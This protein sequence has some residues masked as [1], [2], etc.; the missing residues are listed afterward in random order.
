MSVHRPT[1]SMH[2]RVIFKKK[3]K[4]KKN[5]EIHLFSLEIR[6]KEVESFKED[7][8]LNSTLVHRVRVFHPARCE[9]FN[10]H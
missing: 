8:I 3:N 1:D 2:L 4:K 5:N 10:S 9:V 6:K 7:L